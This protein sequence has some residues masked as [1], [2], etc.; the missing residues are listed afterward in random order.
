MSLGTQSMASRKIQFAHYIENQLLFLGIVANMGFLS[1][2]IFWRQ[3]MFHYHVKLIKTRALINV[4]KIFV[5][6][7]LIDSLKKRVK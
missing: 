7:V 1:G 3:K 4:C 6:L 5:P 2:N